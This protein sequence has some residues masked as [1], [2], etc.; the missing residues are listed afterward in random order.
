MKNIFFYHTDIGKICIADN[1]VAITNLFFSEQSVP[2]DAEINETAL[3]LDAGKQL[4]DYLAGKRKSFNLI[5]APDG[6]TF[7]QSVWKALLEIPFGETRSYGEIAKSIGNPKASRAVGMANNKNP[8]AIFIPCHRVIGANGK[9]VGYAGGLDVK[10][11]L[12]NMEKQIA[13][14]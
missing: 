1:G 6:T 10:E 11:R 14:S 12:L 2:K 8:I 7:Q 4:Q 3:L 9:L 5:L 13:N